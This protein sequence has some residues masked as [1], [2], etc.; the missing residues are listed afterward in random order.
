M[1]KAPRRPAPKY[2]WDPALLEKHEISAIKAMAAQHAVGFAAIVEKICRADDLSFTVGGVDG[3]RATDYAEGKRA[4]GV[5]LRAIV[6][7]KLDMTKPGDDGPRGA[8]PEN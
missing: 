7:M 3:Q 4:V 2:P 1:G 6:K 8:P 5:N